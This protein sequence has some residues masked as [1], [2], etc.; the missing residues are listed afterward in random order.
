MATGAELEQ[1]VRDYLARTDPEAGQV[2]DVTQRVL[3]DS[4]SGPGEKSRL[5]ATARAPA[6]GPLP[7]TLLVA[8]QR[9]QRMPDLTMGHISKPLAYATMFRFMGKRDHANV[10]RLLRGG[11][12]RIYE[13]SGST[14]LGSLARKDDVW[15]AQQRYYVLA[16]TIGWVT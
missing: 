4:S 10:I 11:Y 6:P 7:P 14:P 12:L 15:G 16:P 8:L 9:I 1:Q 13:V 5:V 3:D 2:R